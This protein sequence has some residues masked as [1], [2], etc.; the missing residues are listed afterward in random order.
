MTIGPRAMRNFAELTDA[1]FRAIPTRDE[2]EALPTEEIERLRKMG[3]VFDNQL[4]RVILK[5]ENAAKS[6]KKSV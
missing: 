3:N 4:Y 2:V 5:R 6:E 1:I